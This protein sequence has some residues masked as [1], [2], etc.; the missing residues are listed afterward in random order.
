MK[1]VLKFFQLILKGAVSVACIGLVL[2]ILFQLSFG[3]GTIT[4]KGNQT[5]PASYTITQ[6]Y[7]KYITNTF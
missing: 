6:R 3:R 4:H 2:T 7:N 1:Y 5:Q